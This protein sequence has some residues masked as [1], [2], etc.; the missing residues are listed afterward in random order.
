MRGSNINRLGGFATF[1]IT[2]VG[3]PLSTASGT[4][5]SH[6]LISLL[7]LCDALVLLGGFTWGNE[8][9]TSTEDPIH[10]D[11]I[12]FKKWSDSQTSNQEKTM[13][14][15]CFCF[16]CWDAK[17]RDVVVTVVPFLELSISASAASVSSC[18]PIP[19][20][21]NCCTQLIFC[22]RSIRVT[23]WGHCL[24]CGLPLL[25]RGHGERR[26]GGDGTYKIQLQHM[27]CG[28]LAL[29]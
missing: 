8:Y 6:L 5:E 15:F 28:W 12:F 2:P 26:W 19:D 7:P 25:Q 27:A 17:R 21:G 10:S 4:R 13:S 11:L 16:A 20:Q 24:D 29:P 18:L 3:E 1:Q 23:R 9:P 22:G 14:W